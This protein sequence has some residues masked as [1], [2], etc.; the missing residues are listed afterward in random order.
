MSN[1]LNYYNTL[2]NTVED[3]ATF[4][5]EL[6]SICRD[7]LK[8]S[9]GFSSS[10]LTKLISTS[11][12]LHQINQ[13]KN[14]SPPYISEKRSQKEGAKF[15]KRLLN[16]IG[17]QL[18][19]KKLFKKDILFVSANPKEFYFRQGD[20]FEELHSDKE[21]MVIKNLT[22][23]DWMTVN[24][25]FNCNYDMLQSE[26]QFGGYEIVHFSS[27]GKED[28]I[29]LR[30]NQDEIDL[31]TTQEIKRIFNVLKN[32]NDLELVFLNAC[33]SDQMAKTLKKEFPQITFMCYNIAIDTNKAIEY[34]NKFYKALNTELKAKRFDNAYQAAYNAI[35]Q[36]D[37]I[38]LKI[39]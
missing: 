23:N 26:L 10:L 39:I 35:V 8:H 11:A 12:T 30:K 24:P 31:L 25:C 6:L 21:F 27:H 18:D 28:G 13:D 36:D 37:T 32:N 16:D 4:E 2:K 3:P 1:Y 20:N 33:Y 14:A 29:V 17:N 7:S 19:E 34:S 9:Q 15:R 5:Q 22:Q 38:Q